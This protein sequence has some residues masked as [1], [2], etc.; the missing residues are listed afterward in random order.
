MFRASIK[1]FFNSLLVIAALAERSP[2]HWHLKLWERMQLQILASEMDG[3]WIFPNPPGGVEVA[4]AYR[5]GMVEATSALFGLDA[6]I[7]GG[8]TLTCGASRSGKTTVVKVLIR[9]VSRSIPSWVF[10]WNGEY[11][12]LPP[13]FHVV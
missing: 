11:R 12:D 3:S 5:L 6:D 1:A 8:G 4:G 2:A 10:S 9:G 13:S 7:L